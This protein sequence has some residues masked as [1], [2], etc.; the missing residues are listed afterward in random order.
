MYKCGKMMFA[1]IEEAIEHYFIMLKLTGIEVEII[2]VI[3]DE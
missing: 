3:D 1:T 2:K